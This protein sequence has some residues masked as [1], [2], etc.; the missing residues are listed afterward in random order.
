LSVCFG[1]AAG[2]EERAGPG[3]ESAPPAPSLRPKETKGGMMMKDLA[4]K[5]FSLGLGLLVMTK[6]QVE[7][8]VDE[9]V[10]K[11]KISADESKKM[12]NRLIEAGEKERERLDEVLREKVKKILS[13]LDVPS[14]KDLEALEERVRRLEERQQ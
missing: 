5:G 6:E 4:K 9:L 10:K 11:G 8:A 3:G 14:K 12:V 7:K 2:Y 1:L 13:E